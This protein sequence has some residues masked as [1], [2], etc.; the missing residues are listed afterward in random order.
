MGTNAGDTIIAPGA[1]PAVFASACSASVAL[2]TTEADITGATVTFST[3]KANAKYL[4]IGS[5]YMS[6]VVGSANVAAGKLNVDGA[7]QAAFANFTGIS[8]NERANV[9][10]SW[11][12]TLAAAGSHTLKLRGVLS[13]GT[14]TTVNSTHTTIT[15]YVF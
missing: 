9:A 6:A 5:F 3:T 8:T 1:F 7:N 12:G 2:T 4:V 10:Q 15:V 14:G 13:A 11:S